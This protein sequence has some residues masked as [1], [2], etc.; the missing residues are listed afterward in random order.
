M[1]AQV[2]VGGKSEIAEAVARINGEVRE[3][4][5]FFEEPMSAAPEASQE[6]IFA[7][8][9]PFTVAAGGADYSR[10]SIYTPDADQ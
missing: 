9:E 5:V 2:V 8:M 7:E 1:K 3:A 6:D 10:Q 4:I